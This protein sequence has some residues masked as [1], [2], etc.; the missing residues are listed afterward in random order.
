MIT[1]SDTEFWSRIMEQMDTRCLE[2]LGR[3]LP[4]LSGYA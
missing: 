1:G 2:V 3:A 4:P